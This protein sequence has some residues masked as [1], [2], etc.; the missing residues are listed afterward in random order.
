MINPNTNYRIYIA[1]GFFARGKPQMAN[2]QLHRASTPLAG[3][4]G[5]QHI[6]TLHSEV[7]A[8]RVAADI[9]FGSTVDIVHVGAVVPASIPMSNTE[10]C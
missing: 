5:K 7:V 6:G 9:F 4:L 2:E 10:E 8:F 3:A 1:S